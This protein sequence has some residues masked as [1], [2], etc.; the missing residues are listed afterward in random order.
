[1]VAAFAAAF[2]STVGTQLN[3]GA[4]YLVNDFYRASSTPT[5]FRPPLRDGLAGGDG[6]LT[7]VSAIVT[8]Y[9]DSIAGAWK[10]PDRD[11]RRHGRGADS[12]LVLVAHQRVE[13]GFGHGCAAFSF[14][15]QTSSASIATTRFSSRT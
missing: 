4:S 8:W 15:L 11:R 5:S 6:A 14:L 1:M 3:W 13:R 12:A 7:I 10:L 9:M 2:M